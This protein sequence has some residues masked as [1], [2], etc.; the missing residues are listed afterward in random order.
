MK[1]IYRTSEAIIFSI[2]IFLL[3]VNLVGLFTTLRNPAIYK[4]TIPSSFD[5]VLSEKQLYEKINT[6]DGNKA[7]YLED[8]TNAINSGIAHYWRDEGIDKYNLRIPFH[9]NYLLYFAS[10]INPRIFLKYEFTDYKRAIERGVGLCSQHAIIEAE[11]LKEKGINSRMVAL[12]GHVVLQSEVSEKNN[13]WW[14]LDPDYG[15][16]IPYSISDIEANPQIIK[17]YYSK[18]GYDEPTILK[19]VSVYGKEGNRVINGN[20]AK[21][22]H[23]KKWIIE[24]LS[25]I[26]IWVIPLIFMLPLGIRYVMKRA[27]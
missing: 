25:Y 12:S 14:V 21:H 2:G 8:L 1:K 18:A 15:V 13:E 11:V 22:Y 16:V 5:L 19:L 4:E 3:L 26:L 27:V 24:Q 17:D 6:F 7:I 10:I 20:G 9:E 23:Y